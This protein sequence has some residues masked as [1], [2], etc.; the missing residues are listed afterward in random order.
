MMAQLQSEDAKTPRQPALDITA[1]IDTAAPAATLAARDP[2]RCLFAM[3]AE[4]K[5]LS[6]GYHGVLRPSVSPEPGGRPR[7]LRDHLADVAAR[8]TARKAVAYRPAAADYCSDANNSCR[9]SPGGGAIERDAVSP[10]ASNRAVDEGAHRQDRP[11]R[12]PFASP[13][14]SGQYRT[15]ADGP[16][17][18]H[19][20]LLPMAADF[21]A[22][23][24]NDNMVGRIDDDAAIP[25][26]DIRGVVRYRQHAP[27]VS[28]APA[29]MQPAAAPR[30]S[31]G[32]KGVGRISRAAVEAWEA[33]ETW[34]WTMAAV[35][36]K[37]AHDGVGVHVSSRT[38]NGVNGER[39]RAAEVQRA[40]KTARPRIVGGKAGRRQHHGYDCCCSR[41]SGG[42]LNDGV[43]RSAIHKRDSIL[44]T[45]SR[46]SVVGER[47]KCCDRVDEVPLRLASLKPNDS[48][49][50]PEVPRA[51]WSE[52]SLEDCRVVRVFREDHDA[53][54]AVGAA[55]AVVLLRIERGEQ[56]WRKRSLRV[57][58]IKFRDNRGRACRWRERE[59]EAAR[60]C[61]KVRVVRGLRGM[62]VW[63]RRARG[64]DE[65]SV[66][67]AA[68][69]AAAAATVAAAAAVADSFVRKRRI[70]RLMSM[71]RR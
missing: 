42:C 64:G 41:L 25:T 37:V 2:S 56:A 65:A 35:T 8:Y 3:C 36:G 53:M 57:A 16:I 31:V 6:C 18:K 20:G 50:A 1:S 45:S 51:P 60:V 34:A 12:T 17:H 10:G 21:A 68:A 5:A 11:C 9:F 70:R 38:Q 32:E 14:G 19:H 33:A 15:T 43:C 62:E 4:V 27:A 58:M 30:K 67:A 61:D 39:G 48:A 66:I 69:A 71:L 23:R 26:E 46:N 44:Y 13:V 54:V 52:G 49:Q 40:R 59:A 55:A 29:K 47:V 22:T 24:S 7:E 28:T 63:L